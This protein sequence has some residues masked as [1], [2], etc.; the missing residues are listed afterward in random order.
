MKHKIQQIIILLLC[1]KNFAN[2]TKYFIKGKHK[3]SHVLHV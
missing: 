1:R 2:S 3:I